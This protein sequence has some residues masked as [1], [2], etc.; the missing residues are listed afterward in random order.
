MA[1]AQKIRSGT[2]KVTGLRELNK[3]LKALGPEAQKELKTASRDVA[4]FVAAD[5]KS[6]AAALGGVAAHVA[7]S[8]GVVGGVSGAGVAFGGARYP[9]AGGAEFGAYKYKQFKPWRGNGQ[10]AGYF[11]YPTIRR[12]ADKIATEF[13]AAVDKVIDKRFPL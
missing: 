5:V 3:S 2:V 13:T 9:M 6:A 7:P 11:V 12:D 10:D 4:T 1:K 8:I